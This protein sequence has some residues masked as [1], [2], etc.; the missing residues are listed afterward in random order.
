[1]CRALAVSPA[2]YYAWSARPESV[3][4]AVNRALAAKI[5]MLHRK[6]RETDGSPSIW[7]ALV[8][9]GHS[10][11]EHRIARLMRAEGIRAKTVKQWRRHNAVESLDARGGEHA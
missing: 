7:D 5:R 8:K 10:V 9:R 1:M 4:G 3:R 2:D 11:G 6:S